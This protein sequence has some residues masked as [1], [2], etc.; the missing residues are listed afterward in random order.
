MESSDYESAIDLLKR[1]RAQVR[2]CQNRLPLVVSL[3]ISP[4]RSSATC[5]HRSL[6]FLTDVGMEI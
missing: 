1:A 3:V 6:S 4:N 5:R 2:H